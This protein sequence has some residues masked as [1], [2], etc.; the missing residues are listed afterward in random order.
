MEYLVE[1]IEDHTAILTINNPPAS[2]WTAKSLQSLRAK[3]LNANKAI[4]VL[5]LTG[6]GQKF[7]SAVADLK[8]FSDGDKG[9]VAIMA[10]HFDEAFETLS[11]FCGVSIA[12]INGYVMGGAWKLL[13]PVIFVLMKFKRVVQWFAV[14]HCRLSVNYLSGYLIPKISPKA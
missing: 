13:W 12:T 2:T 7:F 8:L 4:Y 5:V 9:N 14:K 10:K 6:Q 11:Q 3:V 1:R